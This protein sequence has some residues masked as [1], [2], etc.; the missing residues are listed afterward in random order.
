MVR[1]V[2]DTNVLISA[3]IHDGKSRKLVLELLE[4]HVVV[5]SREMLAEL[6]DVAGRDKFCVKGSQVEKSLSIIVRRARV[7]PDRALF[8]E[9]SEDPDDDKVLNTAYVGKADYIVTGDKHLLALNQF[10]RTKIVTGNQMLCILM[11]E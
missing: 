2:I 3:L 5:V 4:K 10:K 9:I 11:M 1:V 8:N 7:V 6:A